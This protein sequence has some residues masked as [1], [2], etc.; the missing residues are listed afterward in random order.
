MD[1]G[2]RVT[3][4][5]YLFVVW[6]G[7]KRRGV[8]EKTVIFISEVQKRKKKPL[9]AMREGERGVVEEQK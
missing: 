5:C 6:N 3:R 8:D 1:V 2:G 4:G 9:G 7:D